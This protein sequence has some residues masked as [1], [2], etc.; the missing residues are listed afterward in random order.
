MSSHTLDPL[1]TAVVESLPPGVLP[2]TSRHW[3]AVGLP[4]HDE[5]AP[6]AVDTP[7]ATPSQA[8]VDAPEPSRPTSGI[9]VTAPVRDADALTSFDSGP[10]SPDPTSA[11]LQ[12]P[13]LSCP[14]FYSPRRTGS[15]SP[16]SEECRVV[17]LFREGADPGDLLGQD[18]GPVSRLQRS[19]TATY[20]STPVGDEP[21]LRA[22]DPAEGLASVTSAPMAMR[23][24]TNGADGRSQVHRFRGKYWG[25]HRPRPGRGH[26]K[27][28]KHGSS[29]GRGR[30]ESVGRERSKDAD[31]PLPS[32]G[33]EPIHFTVNGEQDPFTMNGDGHQVAIPVD[34]KG[35]LDPVTIAAF[36]APLPMM[37]SPAIPV[38]AVGCPVGVG[39]QAQGPPA[40]HPRLWCSLM[41]GRH[42]APPGVTQP[43][44]LFVP[45]AG[46]MSGMNVIKVN[47]VESAAQ[48]MVGNRLGN[49]VGHDVATTHP[50][51]HRRTRRRC[52]SLLLAGLVGVGLLIIAGTVTVLVV[53]L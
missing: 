30:G 37:T 34:A 46:G 44:T 35:L 17:A 49:G 3:D 47:D 41:N 14:S 11:A 6:G 32:G 5:A 23:E 33:G 39:K 2:T 16:T 21:S 8:D 36:R 38:H 25:L 27:G 45:P 42:L 19:V 15:L 52:L 1:A 43:N 20:Y 51:D 40:G 13:P 18:H 28:S 50:P 48:P 9:S 31:K 10:A 7:P 26:H 4:T 12:R 24:G 22:G 53:V 29:H